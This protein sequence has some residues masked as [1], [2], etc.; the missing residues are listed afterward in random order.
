MDK[1]GRKAKTHKGRKY[2]Q[3]FEPT[4]KETTRKSLFL[5]GSKVS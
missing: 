5:K 3:Q 1:F 2:L 4:T